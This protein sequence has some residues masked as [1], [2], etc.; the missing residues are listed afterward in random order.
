VRAPKAGV[1]VLSET[2][3]PNDFRATLNGR[4][5]RYFRVNH[6]FKA[7]RIPSAGEW[8]VTFEYRPHDWNLSLGLAAVGLLFL[9]A[10]GV[11]GVQ[12]ALRSSTLSNLRDRV[13]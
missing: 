5:V 11:I 3:L 2:F 4:R 13:A 12:G 1:A 10:V 9:M 8:Y 7:V 6:A